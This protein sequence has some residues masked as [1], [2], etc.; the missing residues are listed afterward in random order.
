MACPDEGGPFSPEGNGLLR[1]SLTSVVEEEVGVGWLDALGLW[2]LPEG[3]RLELV[4]GEAVPAVE[5][6]L[7]L[8][9]D[10]ESLAFESCSC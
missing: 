9:D 6:F 2:V 4:E 1:A 8:E 7:L 3:V 5:S 10:F